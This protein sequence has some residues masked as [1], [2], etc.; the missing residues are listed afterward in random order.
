MLCTPIIKHGAT[1]CITTGFVTH[2]RYSGLVSLNGIN[3]HFKDQIRIDSKETTIPFVYGGD[4]GSLAVINNTNTNKKAIGL[5][6]AGNYQGSKDTSVQKTCGKIIN[7]KNYALANPLST[8]MSA[9]GIQL[10]T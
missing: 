7:Y 3:Y 6:F 5:L 9:L 4:S 1:T 8:V 10:H 2:L